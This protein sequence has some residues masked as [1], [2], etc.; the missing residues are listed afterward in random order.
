MEVGVGCTIYSTFHPD[1][2]AP[3]DTIL[4]HDAGNGVIYQHLIRGVK[5]HLQVTDFV[6]HTP[7]YTTNTEQKD[8]KSCG[9]PRRSDTCEYC[10]R[11]F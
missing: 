9:A 2:V 10:D 6:T 11:R 1:T 4:S 7:N 8:C 3:E 5:D